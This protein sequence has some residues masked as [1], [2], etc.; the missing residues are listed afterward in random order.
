MTLEILLAVREYL[1]ENLGEGLDIPFL[2]ALTQKAIDDAHAFC[3]PGQPWRVPSEENGWPFV[4]L[5]HG[6]SEGLVVYLAWLGKLSCIRG[7]HISRDI[8]L[9]D[10]SGLPTIVEFMR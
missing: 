10:P 1:R 2:P 4:Q 8:D 9:G 5:W 7:K 6:T 3:S